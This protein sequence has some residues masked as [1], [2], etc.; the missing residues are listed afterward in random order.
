[1]IIEINKDID[2]YQESVALGLTAKQLI[3]SLI[4]VITGGGIVLLLYRF[5]GLTASAYIAIPVVAP[6]AMGGF[7]S[8]NGMDF[9]TYARKKIHYMFANRALL[10]KSTEMPALLPQAVK[11]EVKEE[12]A[13]DFEKTK[14]KMFHMMII[15][16][17]LFAIL[18]GVMIYLKFIRR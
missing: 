17:I 13:D 1:M 10:Y 16:V 3:F 2:R 5:I 4:S 14:K 7:Y 8:F 9:F 11:Q 6:I 18:I 15:L 12:P